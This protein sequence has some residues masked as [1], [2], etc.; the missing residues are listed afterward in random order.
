MVYTSS[1]RPDSR[2]RRG[3]QRS[4]RPGKL[5]WVSCDTL[6]EAHYLLAVINSDV[7]HDR[8]VNPFMSKGQFGPRDVHKHLWKLPI[9]MYDPNRPHPYCCLPSRAQCHP[10]SPSKPTW[11]TRKNRRHSETPSILA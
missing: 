5:Y 4:N 9:P 3:P 10:G 2:P 8:S 1:G 7:L 11:P 6:A